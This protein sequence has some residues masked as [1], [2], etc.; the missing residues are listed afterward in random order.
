MDEYLKPQASLCRL[1]SEYQAYNSLVVAFDFDSTVYDFHKKGETYEMVINL[2]KD[3]KSIGCY[4]ICFTANSD[5]K[6][7]SE[8]LKS[9]DIPFDS[10]NE[11]PPFFKCNERKIYYNVLLDDRSGLIQTYSELRSLITK[12]KTNEN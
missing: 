3:L 10:I 4:L 2:I 9:K 8:Y 12:I 5:R 1:I 6:F 11:N 7:I